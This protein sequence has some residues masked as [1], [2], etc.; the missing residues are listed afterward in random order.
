M[1][2]MPLA[3]Y[4]ITVITDTANSFVNNPYGV[5]ED[6]TFSVSERFNSRPHSSEIQWNH[7]TSS[8]VALR[9][10]FEAS[11]S[12]WSCYFLELSLTHA[13]WEIFTGSWKEDIRNNVS[14]LNDIAHIVSSESTTQNTFQLCCTIFIFR[15]QEFST[16]LNISKRFWTLKNRLSTIC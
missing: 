5:I 10:Y 7:D 1:L 13:C 12:D 11:D 6:L 14:I 3:Y 9:L 15:V 8:R 2:I 16:S 4:S